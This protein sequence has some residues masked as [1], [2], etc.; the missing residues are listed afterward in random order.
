VCAPTPACGLQVD[1]LHVPSM[2]VRIRRSDS[3]TAGV[4]RR[5]CGR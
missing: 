1:D 5:G 3:S 2:T 4:I